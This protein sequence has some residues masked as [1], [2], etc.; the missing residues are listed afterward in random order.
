LECCRLNP[1]ETRFC[2]TCGR[3]SR[4]QGTLRNPEKGW[5]YEVIDVLVQGGMSTTYR[6]YNPQVH[7]LAVLKEIN[8]DLSRKA[9]ARELF[10][11]EAEIL[12]AL[13]HPGIPKFYDFFCT[14]E[15][16]SLVMELIHGP[17]L[18][19]IEP[20]DI[21]QAVGWILETCEILSYL[22]EQGVI[23]RDIK[24]AN[25]ILRHNPRRMVL[26]DFGAV[27]EVGSAPGTRIATPGYGAPEQ[28]QGRPCLQSD[29][30]GLGMTLVYLLTRQSPMRFY[31]PRAQRLMG[32]EE[33]GLPPAL[34]S[35]ILSTT[36]LDPHQ[37]P[38]NCTELM[39]A[40]RPFVA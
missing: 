32:L 27:K 6:V 1:P 29:F 39:T 21:A 13:Q 10:I 38:P 8:A 7:R 24:P 36:A 9:K 12:Q 35:V 4:S 25:L 40:L 28:N 22:H 26:I 33:A 11:R 37:R 18:E 30:Y 5:E 14:D 20:V 17:T 15:H 34:V 3:L 31:N 2:R 23:H 16:Y 19:E